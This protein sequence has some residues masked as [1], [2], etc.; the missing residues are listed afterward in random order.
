MVNRLIKL[1]KVE[2][3]KIVLTLDRIVESNS[4]AKK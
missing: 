2:H 4:K 3:G 1:C